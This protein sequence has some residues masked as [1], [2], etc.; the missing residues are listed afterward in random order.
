[1]A[2]SSK[3]ALTVEHLKFD[4]LTEI[5]HRAG[6]GRAEQDKRHQT[7]NRFDVRY[8]AHIDG[9]VIHTYGCQ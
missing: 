5:L 7:D 3:C 1:M 4:A 9:T 6:L 2:A 8:T